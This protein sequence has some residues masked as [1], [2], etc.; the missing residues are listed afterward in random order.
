MPRALHRTVPVTEDRRQLLL[1]LR[2]D[3]V[4]LHQD[5]ERL[6]QATTP[7]LLPTTRR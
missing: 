7:A 1:P 4:Q 3:T 5:T 6:L 2:E